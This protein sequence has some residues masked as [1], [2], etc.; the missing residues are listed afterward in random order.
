MPKIDEHG[1]SD[2]ALPRI[3]HDIGQVYLIVTN[4]FGF[5]MQVCYGTRQ[6]DDPLPDV[7]R[8][9]NQLPTPDIHQGLSR[10]KFKNPIGHI[11]HIHGHCPRSLQLWDTWMMNIL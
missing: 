6:F 5:L 3:Q 4:D 11:S 2:I 1:L 8:V 7:L 10:Y 9:Q